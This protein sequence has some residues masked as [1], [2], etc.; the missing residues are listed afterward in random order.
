MKNVIGLDQE[1]VQ[2]YKRLCLHLVKNKVDPY[3]LD[4]LKLAFLD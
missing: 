1:S 3:K 2:R 4:D